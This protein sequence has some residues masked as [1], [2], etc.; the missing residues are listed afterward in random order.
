MKK[1][2]GMSAVLSLVFAFTRGG[3]KC[4]IGEQPLT[5]VHGKPVKLSD[6]KGK[7]VVLDFWFTGC[8]NCMKFFQG[9]LSAAE[10]HF[11]RDPNVVFVSICIDKDKDTWLGSLEK[12]KYASK[13][14]TN[15]YTN[16]LGDQHPIIKAF[17][18]V[19]YPQ[20]IVLDRMGGVISR[21][22]SLTQP[23]KLIETIETGLIGFGVNLRQE[24][25]VHATSLF[26]PLPTHTPFPSSPR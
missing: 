2:I 17:D 8:I 22:N 9:E 16:G 14:S 15:L 20:P 24:T 5:S 10:R 6:Y 26:Y 4:I 1:I 23:G 11:E 25:S 13:I 19:S 18:V 21:S 12:G 7:V 3:G